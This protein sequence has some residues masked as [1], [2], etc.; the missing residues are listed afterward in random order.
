[1]RTAQLLVTFIALMQH[2]ATAFLAPNSPSL[3][4]KTNRKI[5]KD[6]Q[7]KLFESQNDDEEV[8][9]GSREY[10]EGFISSPIQGSSVQERGSGLE[11]ALKLAG[12]F[13]VGL[14]ILFIGFMASNGLL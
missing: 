14:V 4:S 7:S 12:S 13:T 10:L 1:M 2:T 8:E 5:I 6:I 11:Q 3:A 9:V